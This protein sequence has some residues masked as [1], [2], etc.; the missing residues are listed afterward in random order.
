MNRGM[1]SGLGV[2]IALGAVAACG[3]LIPLAGAG[4]PVPMDSAKAVAVAERNVCGR[5]MPPADSVCVVTGYSHGDG[6]YTVRLDRHPPAGNDHL[7][8]TLTDNGQHIV[9]NQVGP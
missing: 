6:R 9:V 8:V 2:G 4:G 5:A 1:V 7:I 3:G